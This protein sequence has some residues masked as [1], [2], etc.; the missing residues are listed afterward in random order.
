MHHAISHDEHQERYQRLQEL[1]EIED[2]DVLL[3]WTP[4]NLYYL[5]G[6]D[7]L[8]Y[9][10]P[11]CLVASAAGP[12]VLIIRHFETPNV[13][14]LTW[15]EDYRG[16]RDHERMADVVKEVADAAGQ[17]IGTE[18]STWFKTPAMETELRAALG[19]RI[20]S[21]HGLIE[22]LRVVKSPREIE[23]IRIAAG[24][25]DIAMEAAF[26]SSIV[27]NTEDDVAAAV[28]QRMISAGSSYPSLAPFVATGER[29][30]LPHAT[31][32]GRSLEQGDALF[33]ETGG[34][35]GRYSAGLIRTGSIGGPSA[36]Q[37]PTVDRAVS[38]VA[39]ALASLIDAIRPGV[40]GHEIDEAG[41]SIIAG[42]GFG[43][44]HRNRS[45]YSIGISYPPDWGEGHIFSL[46]EGE[47]RPVEEGMVFHLVPNVLLPDAAGIAMSETVLVTAN[48][49][50]VLT[51]YPREYVVV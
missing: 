6:F 31:W 42:A 40:T 38:V 21:T 36:A 48:G 27:G 10:F 45:G 16:Y 3:S 51:N 17:R 39:E 26:E 43:E 5:T 30:A 15:L 44:V 18:S 34:N 4:E 11:Q 47:H 14:A 46:R 24:Y 22:T 20:I 1:M 12:P 37:R 50:E 9:Y 29:T 35:A 13:P 33:Y 25:T 7:T 2:L 32:S 28:Y 8:G 19:D 41:R 49:C 23:L